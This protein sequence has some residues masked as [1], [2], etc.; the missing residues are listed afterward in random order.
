MTAAI[1]VMNRRSTVSRPVLGREG[2]VWDVR[3]GYHCVAYCVVLTIDDDSCLQVYYHVT[4]ST[5][6]QLAPPDLTGPGP[7]G[8]GCCGTTPADAMRVS[9]IMTVPAGATLV[10]ISAMVRNELWTPPTWAGGVKSTGVTGR[11]YLTTRW[12]RAAETVAVYG[13]VA[14]TTPTPIALKPTAEAFTYA[15]GPIVANSDQ[16]QCVLMAGDGAGVSLATA[17]YICS[18]DP[19]CVG[20]HD[21]G[22]DGSGWRACGSGVVWT[23]TSTDTGLA[24]TRLKGP[25]IE[26]WH[27]WTGSLSI[28]AQIP[29]SQFDWM[30]LC[31]QRTT[32]ATVPDSGNVA[33]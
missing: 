31:L 21:A 2:R 22:C 26:G 18:G 14:W 12:K 3:F 24:C 25:G 5:V 15:A 20:I 23:V 7:G 28:A 9:Q 33:W 13:T 30:D 4:D 16:D 27:R 11:G 32:S 17:E 6:I 19:D 8:T 29:I 10:T 1:L